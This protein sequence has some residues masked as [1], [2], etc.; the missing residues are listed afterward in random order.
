MKR[1]SELNKMSLEEVV[2]EWFDKGVTI[3]DIKKDY[4]YT[5]DQLSDMERKE[6]KEKI[7]EESDFVWRNIDGTPL[8]DD[9]GF[10]F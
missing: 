6:L 5:S 2:E 7:I 3:D 9:G 10:W 1:V 8:D 4:G